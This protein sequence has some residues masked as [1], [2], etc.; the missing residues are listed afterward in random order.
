MGTASTMACLT[1]ALGLMPLKGASAPAVSAARLR[2]AEETGRNAIAVAA[3][4]RTPQ[5]ILSRESFLNALIVLQ[6][7]GG[8]TNGIVH[9]LAIVNRHPELQGAITLKDIDE[10][11]RTTP[12]I[13]DLK[14]SG[15]NYMTDFHN[16]G[17]MLALLQTL[18]PLLHL[19]ALTISGQ[20]LGEVLDATPFKAFDYSASIIRPLSNPLS[21][22]SSLVVLYGNLAPHGGVMKASASKDRSLLSHSGRAV[23]FRNAADLALRIDSPDLEVTPSSVLVLQSIGPL[24]YPGMPEAG[25]IPIPRKLS[26]EGVV[27]MLRISDG[28]MSGT[29]GGTIVLHVSPESALPDSVLGIVQDGDQIT[30]DVESRTLRLEVE[31]VEIQRR[32]KR[33]KGLLLG[34]SDTLAQ[35]SALSGH[36]T[37]RGYRGL[38]LRTVN[39]AHEGADFDFLTASGPKPTT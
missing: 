32:I 14:P 38:Y 34:S 4:K 30:C 2:I 7:I 10:V 19:S 37:Q 20:T 13:V 21:T 11:G 12:L 27:D 1:A 33:R 23:V 3:A 8:S 22:S 17:G 18:R 6:A 9:L 26:R 25:L 15:D 29:A 35:P 16:A 31:D 28:R 24:G 39:Q 36:A 5:A